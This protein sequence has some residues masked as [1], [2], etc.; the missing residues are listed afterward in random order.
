MF[1]VILVPLTIGLLG[2]KRLRP[3]AKS[4][5]WLVAFSFA[6][7]AYSRA[8]WI[9]QEPNLFIS[10]FSSII[11][12]AIIC[13]AFSLVLREW[14]GLKFFYALVLVFALTSIANSVFIQ[15][16]HTNN[17]YAKALEYSLIIILSILYFF[18]LSKDVSVLKLERDSFFWFNA[19][20]LIYYSGSLFIFLYSNYILKYSVDL[21]M[22]IW[23]VHALFYLVYNICLSVSLWMGRRK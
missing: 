11:E 22:R 23:F 2:F 20:A 1:F 13:W 10:H 14:I 3:E 16:I 21:G 15:P 17:S 19:G 7:D 8:L 6:T 4:V 9:F 12:F 18:K 5:F